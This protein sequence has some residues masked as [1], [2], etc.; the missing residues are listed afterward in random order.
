MDKIISYVKEQIMFFQTN[1]INPTGIN[2]SMWYIE[3]IEDYITSEIYSRIFPKEMSYKDCAFS[4]A[5]IT[6]D[7]IQYDELKINK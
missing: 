4:L 7:W 6:L 3:I 2:Q 5:L 1:S